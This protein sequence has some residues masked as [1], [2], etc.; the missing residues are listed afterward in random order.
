MK[1]NAPNKNYSHNRHLNIM[2]WGGAMIAVGAAIML[3]LNISISPW[4][5]VL[6]LISSVILAIWGWYSGARGI[7]LQNMVFIVI[8][9]LAI[10]R[11]LIVV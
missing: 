9:L 11:W 5:F 6:Y 1:K 8:N 4:A 7:A 3:A 2:E 10:Y